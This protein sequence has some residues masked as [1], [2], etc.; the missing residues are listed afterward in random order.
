MLTNLSPYLCGSVYF[1]GST[2]DAPFC[3]NIV[4]ELNVHISVLSGYV[5]CFN[6]V[7]FF[8][9]FLKMLKL[10]SRGRSLRFFSRR[11]LVTYDALSRA[12]P[13]YTHNPVH[14]QAG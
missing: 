11:H 14:F 1:I 8:V 13:A 7:T 4:N 2:M 9:L 5:L 12:D 3:P 6:K 10:N